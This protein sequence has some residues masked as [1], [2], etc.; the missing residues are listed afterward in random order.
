MSEEP[1]P[2][3]GASPD[4]LAWLRLRLQRLYRANGEP[5]SREVS[6]RTDRAVSHTT[7]NGLLKCSKTPRWSH[8][9][10]VVTALGGDVEEFRRL[11]VAVRDAEDPASSDAPGYPREPDSA[12]P[13]DLTR[14]AWPDDLGPASENLARV[15]LGDPAAGHRSAPRQGTSDGRQPLRVRR[16]QLG[17]QELIAEGADGRVFRLT[18]PHLPSP[19]PLAF[20]EIRQTLGAAEHARVVN[21][22]ERAVAIRAT[23]DTDTQAEID[24]V[25]TWPT[26]IVEERGAT[27]GVLMP[28]LPS[29]FFVTT[30]R[31]GELPGQVI[32]E[33]AFLCTTDTYLKT[34]GIDRSGADD[35][36]SRLALAAQLCYAV[37]LLHRHDIV[38]GDLSLRNV[39]IATNPPRI[40]LLDCD[41]VAAL[42]D[43][44]RRQL[45]SPF[46]KPPEC[47]GGAQQDLVTDVYKLA[48]CVLRGMVTGTGVTQLKDPGVLSGLVDVEGVELMVRSLSANRTVRPTAAELRRYLEHV[49]MSQARE[50]LLGYPSELSLVISGGQF[51]EGDFV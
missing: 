25:T 21:S 12:H 23:M 36:L 35:P 3:G 7:V 5:S 45:H 37:E 8:L 34:M 15:P 27:V 4:A 33:F 16:D 29:E 46:F 9:E 32:F 38:Y 26:A 1:A 17:P 47:V 30:H 49:V 39:A 6:R 11:W 43:T 44:Q 24:R 42:A 40:K 18:A 48:L 51:D 20:K 2:I 41:G 14:P 22:M 28:L 10:V 50:R 19:H 31:E 13:T